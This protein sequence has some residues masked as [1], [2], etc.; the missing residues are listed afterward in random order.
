[1]IIIHKIFCI[2]GRTGV[3]KSVITN[4]AAQ[5]LQMKILKSYTTRSMRKGETIEK[6][7]HT[8]IKPEEVDQYR[9]DMVAYTD[10]VD[11]CS[12][13]TRQQ[14]FNSDFYIINPTGLYELKLKTKDMD[15][16][17]IPV[18]INVPYRQNLENAKKRGDLESW[19]ANYEK[20]NDEFKSFEYSDLVRY[21][22]LN[23]GTIDQA[24]D[25]LVRI[26]EKERGRDKT[27]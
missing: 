4:K 19:K 17:L 27:F 25:K 20:E 22:I 24:V 9:G 23:N 10:R 1:M 15:I 7:D 3:G 18:Y 14:L 21:R 16:K 12:F 8:F 26:V 6:S 2:I 13:A 5:T 11:Y